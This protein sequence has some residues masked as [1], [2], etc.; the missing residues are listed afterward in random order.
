M[1]YCGENDEFLQEKD[2]SL[3]VYV[4]EMKSDS[5]GSEIN[6]RI[7]SIPDFHQSPIPKLSPRV[8]RSPVCALDRR[9]QGKPWRKEKETRRR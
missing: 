6:E 1:A 8:H 4:S 3:C 9:R 7:V 5:S 2:V